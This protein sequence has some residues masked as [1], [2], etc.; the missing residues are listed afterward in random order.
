MFAHL[1]DLRSLVLGVLVVPVLEVLIDSSLLTVCTLA[2]H[3]SKATSLLGRS[4]VHDL[5]EGSIARVVLLFKRVRSHLLSRIKE[6]RRKKETT[7]GTIE[8]VERE[9]KSGEGKW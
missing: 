2:Q 1:S 9:E 6:K 5:V 8:A 7:K 3:G 4:A